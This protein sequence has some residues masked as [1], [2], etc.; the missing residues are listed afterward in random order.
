MKDGGT[1]TFYG[2]NVAA[3]MEDLKKYNDKLQEGLMAVED[4]Q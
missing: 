2:D 3:A 1:S 4:I